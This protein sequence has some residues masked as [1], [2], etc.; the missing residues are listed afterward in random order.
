MKI[1][2]SVD[3]EGLGGITQWSD[4][5]HGVRY[6]QNILIEQLESF[7]DAVG[8]NYVLV[9]DSHAMG[10]NILWD[11]TRKYDNV[12]IISG[13]FRKNYMMTGLDETFDRVVFFGYHAG[14]GTRYAVMDHTYSSSSIFNVWINGKLMNEALINAAYAG[15]FN[16]PVAMIVGDDKL[17]GQVKLKNLFYVET[18]TS[19]GRFSAKHRS[20]KKVINDIKETTKKMLEIPKEEFEI[21]KFDTPVELVVELSDTAR[22]DLIEMIPLV[23]RFDG[24]KVRVVH[25][26][27]KVIFDA[28]LSIAYMASIVKYIGR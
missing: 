26:D 15:I 8:E 7:L 17:K 19:L 9:S 20:M 12:E 10:D 4:V 21:F 1:Y 3:F 22:A 27:Y 25:E 28:I 16:V 11:I 5:V 2:V 13:N 24:R 18:K 6:K 23:E 14:I